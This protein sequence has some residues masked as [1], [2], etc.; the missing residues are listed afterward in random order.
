MEGVLGKMV[1]HGMNQKWVCWNDLKSEEMAQ[2]VEM[3]Y[4]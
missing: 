1:G 4:C 3:A 2:P